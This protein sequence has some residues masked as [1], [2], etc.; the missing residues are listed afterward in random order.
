[1]SELRVDIKGDAAG[2]NATLN[3]AKKNAAA[4]NQSLVAQNQQARQQSRGGRQLAEAGGKA[5]RLAGAAAGMPGLGEVGGFAAIAASA[6]FGL[7]EAAS[8]LGTGMLRAGALVAV[9]A[10]TIYSLKTLYTEA[11]DKLQSALDDQLR[12]QVDSMNEE[13]DAEK[14]YRKVLDENRKSLSETDYKRLRKGITS[15]DRGAM[16]EVRQ[17]FGGTEL[18]KDLAKQLVRARIEAM[19]DGAAKSVAMENYRA[20]QERAKVRE[21]IGEAPSQATQAVARQ[22]FAAINQE[23]ANKLAEINKRQ[24]E[25]LQ[26]INTN[27][28]GAGANPFR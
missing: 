19:P 6:F 7:K 14:A 4:F 13:R 12:T 22:L 9:F 17:R 1:M 27:T 16:A 2:F 24:L 26:K 21:Q 10:A 23:S 18:N 20:D 11:Y 25:E 8:A 15:G 3:Q 5:S 28:K